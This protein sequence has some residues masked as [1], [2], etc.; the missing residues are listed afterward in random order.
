MSLQ[1][2]S[3]RLATFFS[4]PSKETEQGLNLAIVP[5]P[6]KSLSVLIDLVNQ[7]QVVVS[8]LPL[9]LVHADGCDTVEIHV[10]TAPFDGHLYGTKDLFPARPENL[11]YLLPAHPLCPS[12]KKPSIGIG[13][14]MLAR[15]PRNGFDSNTTHGAIHTPHRVNEKDA[16]APKGNKLEPAGLEGVIAWARPAANRTDADGCS[17]RGRIS[18]SM[19]LSCS[20]S[21]HGPVDKTAVFLNPI[22]YSLKLHPVVCSSV[23][24]GF[25]TY[26]IPRRQ[27]DALPEAVENAMIR[28]IRTVPQTTPDLYRSL[29]AFSIAFTNQFLILF[30]N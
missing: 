29:G 6:K 18:I 24:V 5:D 28:A 7:G 4:E 8:P 9:D 17:V 13:Q 10:L 20:D 30:L 27:R 1:T 16:E 12:G 26:I 25:A 23:D 14:T 21:G 22:Q 11:G 2:N 15:S 19:A 3:R